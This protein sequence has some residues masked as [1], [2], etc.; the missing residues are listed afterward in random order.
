MTRMIDPAEQRLQRQ[1]RRERIGRWVAPVLSLALLLGLWQWAIVAHDLKPYIL[2]P[3]RLVAETLVAEFPRLLPALLNTLKT[4]FLALGVAVA[5]G[6]LIAI[7]FV[8]SKW[9]EMLFSPYTVILQ[10]TPI[11]VVAPYITIYIDDV[12]TQLLVCAW[13]VAFFPILSNTMVGLKSADHRL[14]DLFQLHGAGRWQTLR[15][16]TLPAA[17]PY[18]L[19]GL[20]IAG[21]LALIGAVVAEFVVGAAGRGSGLAYRILEAAYRVEIARMFAATVLI[22]LTG[23]LLYLATHWLSWLLM[24]RWHDSA[25]RRDD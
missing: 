20:R 2:P 23:I 13:I 24:H 9:L 19:A 4:T 15:L 8:Q 11:I 17:L 25:V 12:G 6:V 22:S 3:P 16:L 5:G 7:V 18:F 14:R 1:R 10:T 21:G